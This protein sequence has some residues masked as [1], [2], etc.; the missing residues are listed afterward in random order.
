MDQV[1]IRPR[2][3]PLPLLSLA[4]ALVC[5]V[6]SGADGQSAPIPLLEAPAAR[7]VSGPLVP[8]PYFQGAVARGTRS[9]DGRPGPSYWQPYTRT[10]IDARLDPSTG[11][12]T[13]S[14]RI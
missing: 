3:R 9:D 12:V 2:R 4:A 5:L 11:E 6:P 8:P 13:A 14:A 10:Q 1:R 7:P